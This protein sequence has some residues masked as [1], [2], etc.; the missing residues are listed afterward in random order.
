M[1]RPMTK[2]C[3]QKI[4]NV[5]A[6]ALAPWCNSSNNLIARWRW[7]NQWPTIVARIL[8]AQLPHPWP[9]DVTP[10]T[11][12]LPDACRWTNQCCQNSKSSTATALAPWCNTSNNLVA[13]LRW[14]NQQLANVAR[15]LWTYL[16]QP[17]PQDVTPVTILLP[18]ADGQ[19]KGPP[20][21]P[22]Q[23]SWIGTYIPSKN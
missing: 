2:H 4:V 5:L 6:T 16:P 9:Q 18:A 11:I 7:K 8:R 17:W 1:D 13:K 14:I 19:T 23:E 22:E 10:V 15:K 21:S 12:L 20:L 3:C